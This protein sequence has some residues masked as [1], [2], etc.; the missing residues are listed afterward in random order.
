ML[1]HLDT[2]WGEKLIKE[3]IIKLIKERIINAMS[4]LEGTEKAVSHRNCG[5]T[6]VRGLGHLCSLHQIRIQAAPSP[7]MRMILLSFIHHFPTDP[8]GSSTGMLEAE[9]PLA[10]YKNQ[11]KP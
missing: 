8:P 7:G 11:H 2:L 5:I 9:K 1:Q 10:P 4:D 3:R 6:H